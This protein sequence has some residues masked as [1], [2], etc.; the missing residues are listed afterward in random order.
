M[1]GLKGL[2]VMLFLG[3]I[4][5]GETALA[6]TRIQEDALEGKT[7]E[8][9]LTVLQE[10]QEGASLITGK[11]FILEKEDT[12]H[13]AKKGALST[14]PCFFSITEWDRR[15]HVSDNREPAYQLLEGR[16][17]PFEREDHYGNLFMSFSENTLEIGIRNLVGAEAWVLR[18][19][20]PPER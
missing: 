16:L 10:G 7:G 1:K 8:L 12:L 3:I 6:L 20:F 2:W 5:G 18:W 11:G 19:D 17:I 4:A 15:C 14:N 13:P 9:S